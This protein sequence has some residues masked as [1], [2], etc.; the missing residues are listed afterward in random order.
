LI[1]R[2]FNPA[3][4]GS[5]PRDRSRSM[6]LT[7]TGGSVRDGSGTGE[8]ARAGDAGAAGD[9]GEAH[10]IG[11]SSGGGGDALGASDSACAVTAGAEATGAGSFLTT[12]AGPP[13]RTGTRDH[14]QS[15]AAPAAKPS[16][17]ASSFAKRA[18]YSTSCAGTP[19]PTMP[20][21][22]RASQFV[23]RM[24]PWDWVL[25]TVDGSGVPWMP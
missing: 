16:R 20:A 1:A 13:G 22:S 10:A 24:Q 17:N 14:I 21:S 9:A 3:S 12:G 4:G 19:G 5:S 25:P 23:K 11:G 8:A 18:R 6:S 15:A 7:S 2:T